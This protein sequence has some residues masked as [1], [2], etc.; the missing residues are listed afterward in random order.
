L[1]RQTL[2]APDGTAPTHAAYTPG[3]V[4]RCTGHC[5]LIDGV[6][7]VIAAPRLSLVAVNGPVWSNYL[8][9]S[10]LPIRIGTPTMS[11]VA[12]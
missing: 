11:S 8:A 10:G 1:Y 3:K 12:G 4:T 5:E 2:P 7:G 6:A 9:L